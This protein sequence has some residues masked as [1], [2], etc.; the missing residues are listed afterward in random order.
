MKW[1]NKIIFNFFCFDTCSN[2]FHKA[3]I[4]IKLNSISAKSLID[5]LY[6]LKIQ[7]WT[8][9]NLSYACK[10]IWWK[11]MVILFYDRCSSYKPS[12]VVKLTLS[13]CSSALFIDNEF[14][15]PRSLYTDWSIT[16]EVLRET[17]AY[18][19]ARSGTHVTADAKNW[20]IGSHAAFTLINRIMC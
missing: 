6:K 16:S 1:S 11:D 2:F 7:F 20:L 4:I 8:I 14:E 13:T 5:V 15:S 12:S 3:F 9:I 10:S 18:I 17:N 19:E